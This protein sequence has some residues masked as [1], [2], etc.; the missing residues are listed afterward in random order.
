MQKLSK[1]NTYVP[2]DASQV[3]GP[4]TATLNREETLSERGLKTFDNNLEGN[5]RRRTGGTKCNVYVQNKDG[6]PLMPCTPAK[7]RH[8]LEA[9]KARVIQRSPFTIRLSWQ[10][11]NNVQDITLGIDTGAKYIGFSAVTRK[12][13]LIS[14]TVTLDQMLKKRLEQRGNYRRNRRS[15]KWY[16]KPRFLNRAKPNGWLPPSIERRY[17]AH[18]KLIQKIKQ[19]LPITKTTVEIGQ[20]D[21]QK[22]KNP[23]IAGKEYQQGDMYGHANTK[24]YVLAREKYTCQLCNKSV[25]GKGSQLH[26]ITPRGKGGAD[27]PNNLALLHKECHGKLHK[28]NLYHKLKRPKQYKE[29]IF[30]SIIGKRFKESVKCRVTYGYKTFVDRN[31]LGLPKTHYN[32]A[33]VIAGGTTQ[34]RAIPQEVKQIKRNNRSIQKNR[35]GY[36]PSIRRQ[37]YPIQPNDTVLYNNKAYIS[38]GTHCKGKRVI[39]GIEPKNRS[40]HIKYLHLITY[41]KGL[42]F[43]A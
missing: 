26:H 7:A 19:I 30:M 32:D 28:N 8:L 21:I 6:E 42:Q 23:K 10:C 27:L 40:I 11:E 17:Q 35:R 33:F 25:I 14:G 13:E 3:R 5:Q 1:R 2:T 39:I 20:F 31:N 16:R 36:A 9:G 41:G 4:T 18:L 43:V 29:A 34:E 15:R 24:S 12:K 37:K 38:K 22:I